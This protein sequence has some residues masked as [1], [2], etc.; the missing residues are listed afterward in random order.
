MLKSI[1]LVSLIYGCVELVEW[2][3]ALDWIIGMTKSHN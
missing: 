3:G 2:N 1:I